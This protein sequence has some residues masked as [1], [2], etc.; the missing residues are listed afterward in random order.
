M[1][2][3]LAECLPG[4]GG[5]TVVSFLPPNQ[6]H[7]TMPLFVLSPAS[8]V[9]SAIF[10]GY[11]SYLSMNTAV[12]RHTTGKDHTALSEKDDAVYRASR[13]HG[14]F[15][16]Y[17]PFTI[18]LLFLAELNGAPTA[19]VHAAYSTLFVA[20]VAHSFAL[21][22]PHTKYSKLIRAFGFFGTLAVILGAGLYNLGLGYEPL[23]SFLGIQ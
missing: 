18:T 21:T 2:Q 14:N 1:G 19:W 23:K 13:V 11:Y 10:A 8:L 5:P 22:R 16:E 9:H 15:A 20:R 7:L 4:S 17:T 6:Q 12:R 3:Q